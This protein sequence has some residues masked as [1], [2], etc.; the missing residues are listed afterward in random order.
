MILSSII[1]LLVIV[2]EDSPKSTNLKFLPQKLTPLPPPPNTNSNLME[3]VD[4]YKQGIEDAK[5]G[6]P[7]SRY[8]WKYADYRKGYR[9]GL[10]KLNTMH[11]L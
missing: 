7:R 11:Q 1:A 3:F 10:W 6:K 5:A 9:Q 8:Y 2:S 4:M